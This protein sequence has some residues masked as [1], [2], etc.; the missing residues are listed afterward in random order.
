MGRLK[1][2]DLCVTAIGHRVEG[3]L[4]H[5]PLKCVRTALTSPCSFVSNLMLSLMPYL[6]FKSSAELQARVVGRSAHR[7]ALKPGCGLVVVFGQPSPRTV[8][9]LRLTP[10]VLP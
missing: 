1:E 9:R 3:E 2:A 7:A 8:R 10:R 6:A 4:S 5:L